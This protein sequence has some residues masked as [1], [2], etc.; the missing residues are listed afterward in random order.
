MSHSSSSQTSPRPY[1]IRAWHEWMLDNGMT[2]HLLVKVDETVSVPREYVK[3]GE[4][5]LNIGTEATGGLHL[6]N[7]MIRFQARFAGRV[8]DISVPV[9]RVASIFSRENGQGMVF[10][11]L[12]DD[13]TD[14]F[15][16]DGDNAASRQADSTQ[17]E[18]S[19]LA[20]VSKAE[21]KQPD[22]EKSDTVEENEPPQ[23]PI[24]PK[25]GGG[26]RVVK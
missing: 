15:A 25:G 22:A 19:G 26:L 3:N 7:D 6:G 14:I 21:D 1:L 10:E 13:G 9:N 16:D 24:P 11:L 2:P 5:V 8:R 23:N 17:A 20:L 12:D 4:I 18:A